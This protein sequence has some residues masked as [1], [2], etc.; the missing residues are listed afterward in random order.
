MLAVTESF[1]CFLN[2]GTSR[3][4]EKLKPLHGAIASDIA[5]RLGPD[6][7]VL[8][9]GYMSGR[10]GLMQ[11]RYFDKRV[12]ITVTK[13]GKQVAGFSVKFVMQNYSQNSNNYFESMLGETANIRAAGFPYFQ[14]FVVLDRIPYYDKQGNVKHWEGFTPNNAR[15]YRV[16]STDH[17]KGS[18]QT[19]DKTLLY[20]VSLNPLF[21][22]KTKEEYLDFYRNFQFS[23]EL[24]HENY[25]EF[26][27][28]VVYNNYEKFMEKAYYCI[29][30]YS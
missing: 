16:L 1:S 12:D 20:V 11:G 30:A 5:Q 7:T 10:E 4:N 8:S 26:D 6:Y 25:G 24:S 2:K 3:S 13:D 28:A 27:S 21:D 17:T 22:A 15:K 19:P 23:L 14:I 18:P 29:M 9:Q